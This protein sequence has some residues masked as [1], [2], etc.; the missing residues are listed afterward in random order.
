MTLAPAPP[1]HDV[2]DGLAVVRRRR[3]D[4]DPTRPAV[5]LVHGA[6]DRAASFGRVMRRL[7]DVD[8]T[9]YDRRG[10]A[11]SLGAGIAR[12]IRDHAADLAAVAAWT[13]AA[14]V[15]VVGHSLGGSVALC[16]AA[17]APPADA[18]VA[19]GVF[20]APVPQLPGYRSHAGDVALD[21]A[22]RSGPGAAA[23]AFYR[24]LVGDRTWERLRAA[25]R[26]LR[27][28]EGAALVAE[29]TDLRRPAA[30]ADP[31]EV[32]VP[33]AVGAGGRSAEALQLSALALADALPDG[34]LD[35]I[36]GCG[37]GAHLSHPDEFARWVRRCVELA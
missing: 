21:A 9:A 16:A 28:A 26:E 13:G 17:L 20:E 6:M 23:E 24:L 29:L 36:E 35:R 11:G 33:T 15:V 19:L 1:S 5:V 3:D 22:E 2:V 18:P 25:D 31:A 30:V 7:P 32:L 10:Y 12:S 34:R 14:R 4:V 37:H 8:V 27:Q